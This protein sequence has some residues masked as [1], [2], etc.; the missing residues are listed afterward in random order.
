MPNLQ[1]CKCNK[2]I[3]D[4]IESDKQYVDTIDLIIKRIK[5]RFLLYSITPDI[6]HNEVNKNSACYGS[7]KFEVFESTPRIFLDIDFYHFLRNNKLDELKK[8]MINKKI[9]PTK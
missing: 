2:Y 7:F 3:L 4:C 6:C 8:I 1:C 9:K 5:K